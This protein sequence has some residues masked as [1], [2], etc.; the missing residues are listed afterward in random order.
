MSLYFNGSRATTVKGSF[1][2]PPSR[3]RSAPQVCYLGTLDIY[4]DRRQ[5]HP[6]PRPYNPPVVRLRR[7]YLK[8]LLE[9]DDM[10]H[11]PLLWES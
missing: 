5:L 6:V 10:L 8:R 3:Y 4:G 11:D 9:R 2:Y 7:L 1:F